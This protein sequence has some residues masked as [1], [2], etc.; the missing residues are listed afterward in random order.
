[1][2]GKLNKE[3]I[4]TRIENKFLQSDKNC[5]VIKKEMIIKMLQH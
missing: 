5:V 4:I 2:L 3:H 1:M